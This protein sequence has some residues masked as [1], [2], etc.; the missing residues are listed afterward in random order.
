VNNGGSGV[1]ANGSANAGVIINNS[2][3]GGNQ[4]GVAFTAGGVLFSTKTNVISGNFTADGAP[5]N[6]INL[7]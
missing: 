2:L 5:S 1:K 7:N 4:V 3:F 6:F